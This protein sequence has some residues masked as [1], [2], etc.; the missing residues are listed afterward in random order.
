MI[1][2]IRNSSGGLDLKLGHY[3]LGT[4]GMPPSNRGSSASTTE[5]PPSARPQGDC[6]PFG[7]STDSTIAQA[8]PSAFEEQ[9]YSIR[10]VIRVPYLAFPY[11]EHIPSLSPKL[12]AYLAV[13]F[14][15]RP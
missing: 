11:N 4:R 3:P 2:A 14:L 13:A 15:V 9:T 6:S 12:A 8:V 1:S 5:P 10:A 7:S